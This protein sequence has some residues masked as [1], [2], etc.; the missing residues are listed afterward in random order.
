M[1]LVKMDVWISELP[2]FEFAKTA[3]MDIRIRI[4]FQYGCQMDIF[5]FDF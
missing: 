3:N 5:E 2:V 4:R 1:L